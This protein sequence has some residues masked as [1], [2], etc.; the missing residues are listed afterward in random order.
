MDA[1]VRSAKCAR[2]LWVRKCAQTSPCWGSG[3][4]DTHASDNQGPTSDGT[5][6]RRQA[7]ARDEGSTTSRAER[8]R[9]AQEPPTPKELWQA[10]TRTSSTCLRIG[11]WV[12]LL[13]DHGHHRTGERGC[14]GTALIGASPRLGSTSRQTDGDR[15]RGEKLLWGTEGTCSRLHLT[16][17][18][19]TTR[20]RSG[21]RALLEPRHGYAG[22]ARLA[23]DDMRAQSACGGPLTLGQCARDPATCLCTR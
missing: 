3:R 10:A 20:A 5:R 2:T 19:H 1:Q 13:G 16:A 21:T 12:R 15:A 22:H 18:V 9:D 8:A 23:A 17:H 11:R 14:T 4:R 6:E 7:K